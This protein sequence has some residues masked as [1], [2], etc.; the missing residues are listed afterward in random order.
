M[1]MSIFV[2]VLASNGEHHMRSGL[3]A[4][5]AY[6]LSTATPAAAASTE[7]MAEDCAN[8]AQSFFQDF[9]AAAKHQLPVFLQQD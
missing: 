5:L 7:W 8:A 3:L 9:E 4:I 1:S 6:L 2:N